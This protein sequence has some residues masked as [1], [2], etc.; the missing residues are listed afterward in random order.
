MSLALCGLE[1]GL[2]QGDRSSPQASPSS[3]FVVVTDRTRMPGVFFG[4]MLV[5]GPAVFD[6]RKRRTRQQQAL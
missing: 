3:S 1:R 6:T 2:E 4:G 5:V